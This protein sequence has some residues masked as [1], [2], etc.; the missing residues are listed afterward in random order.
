MAEETTHT[1]RP[2]L[3]K[4]RNNGGIQT[5]QEPTHKCDNCGCRRYTPCGCK[6]R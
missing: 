5:G 2:G 1:K 3:K 6:R 4:I